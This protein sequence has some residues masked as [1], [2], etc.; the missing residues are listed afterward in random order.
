MA[1]GEYRVRRGDT[2]Y[3]IA[4]RFR[5]TVEQLRSVNNLGRS[6]IIRPGDRLRIVARDEAE[7][8]ASRPSGPSSSANVI[9]YHVRPGDTLRGIAARHRVEMADLIRWNQLASPDAI[10]AGTTLRVLVN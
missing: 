2:L 8:S 7:S 9:R 4:Q 10:F 3:S 5:M 1:S 6:S